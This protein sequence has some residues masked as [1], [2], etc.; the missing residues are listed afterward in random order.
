MR[1]VFTRRAAC[2]GYRGCS[3]RVGS[4]EKSGQDYAAAFFR[5][6]LKDVA[7]VRNCTYSYH[8]QPGFERIDVEASKWL[9]GQRRQNNRAEQQKFRECEDLFRGGKS[10]YLFKGRLQ[11]KKQKTGDAQGRRNPEMVVADQ[12]ANEIRCQS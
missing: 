11:F 2:H 3:R 12:G 6:F 7:S 4:A 9:V 8:H 5:H 10:R 1:T